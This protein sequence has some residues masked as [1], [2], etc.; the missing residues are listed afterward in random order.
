MKYRE[1][2]AEREAAR[3]PARPS[4]S[5]L[6]TTGLTRLSTLL[7]PIAIAIRLLLVTGLALVLLTLALLT[8]LRVVLLIRHRV[9]LSGSGDAQLPV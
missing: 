3:A 1:V 2:R 7:L 6:R 4:R 8:T 5:A 9:L